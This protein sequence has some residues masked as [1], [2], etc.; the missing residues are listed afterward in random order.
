MDM[1][2]N[3]GQEAVINTTEGQLI[4][5][6]CPGSGKTTTLVRRIHHM[7]DDCKIPS[8]SILMV[9]FSNAAAKEMRE[10]YQKSYGKDDVTFSTIHSL[11]FA[12]L[13]K[14]AGYSNEDI[15]TDARDYF[16]KKLRGNKQVNDKEE[17]INSILTEISVI[18]NNQIPLDDYNPI[19]CNDKTLFEDLFT[20]YEEY[21]NDLNVVDFDDMLIQAY[22]TMKDNKNCLQ[23]LRN[24]Y[25]YIQ[26]DE[27]QDT[28]YLQRDI[29]YL[30]AGENGNLTVVGDDD[31][32]I[33][34]FRGA[35]PQVML[36]FKKDYPDA[37]MIRLST[38]YR[39][40]KEII[41]SADNLI[42]LN[43]SR[44]DKEFLAFKSETGQI[45]YIR[46]PENTKYPK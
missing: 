2:K 46:Q 6:A 30:L 27:Y 32:S 15:L 42:K 29:I 12:I 23:W 13:R 31:Q 34:G 24:K 44:F 40:S 5:I 4:V 41:H 25:R 37:V 33:Y 43:K 16:Y 22:Q 28:N 19:C 9:T 18:K 21:K 38:N 35:R 8:E 45:E 7:V 1:K 26:V 11:C 39:S 10:R 17:F 20:G 3:E 36:N 14:F